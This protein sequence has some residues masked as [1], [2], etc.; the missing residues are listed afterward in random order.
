M[1]TSFQSFNRGGQFQAS[2]VDLGS[3]QQQQV[4][5]Q[6]VQDLE[7]NSEAQRQRDLQSARETEQA[8]QGLAQFSNS[9][10][11]IL[12]ERQKE[13]NEKQ[14]LEGMREYWFNGATEEEQA[15]FRADEQALGEARSAADKA[16]GDFEQGGGDVFVAERLRDL[17]GWKAYGFAKAMLNQAG[18]SYGTYYTQRSQELGLNET[19]DPRQ[20][21][22]IEQQIREDYMMQYAEMNPLLL[23]E[24][25]FPSMRKFEQAEQLAYANRQAKLFQKNRELTRKQDLLSTFASSDPTETAN[26]ILAWVDNH[27]GQFG[28]D[29]KVTFAAATDIIRTGLSDGSIDPSAFLNSLDA[30][31]T[32]RDGSVMT[33]GEFR[34]KDLALLEEAARSALT[35]K[36]NRD[37]EFNKNTD[38]KAYID[39]TNEWKNSDKSEEALARI[40]AKYR[41]NDP[42]YQALIGSWVTN[43]DYDDSLIVSDIE[44]RLNAG[45]PVPLDFVNRISD[46]ETREDMMEKVTTND[47]ISPPESVLEQ[48]TAQIEAAVKDETGIYEYDSLQNLYANQNA[49]AHYRMLY[50]KY[51]EE[52][53]KVN[54]AAEKAAAET[55]KM[56]PEQMKLKK[57]GFF[58][59][60]AVLF[61]TDNMKVFADIN[62]KADAGEIDFDSKI[63]G[64]DNQVRQLN[65]A[66]QSKSGI[67]DFWRTL[68][69]D[70]GV[71]VYKLIDTQLRA[72]GYE[73]FNAPKTYSDIEQ[74]PRNTRRLV[75]FHKTDSRELRAAATQENAR[76][77]LDSIASVESR[78]HGEYNAFNLGG[79]SGGHVAIGS[80]DSTTDLD[81]PITSMT[82]GEIK[83]RHAE[84]SLHAVGRY[85]FIAPT[86]LETA[87]L[88][89]LDDNQVFDEKTQD[90]F[91]LTRAAVRI[92]EMN[93]GSVAGLSAEWIGL[94]NLPAGQVQQMVAF[95]LNLPP[96]RQL[97][98][99]LPGVAKA[100]LKPN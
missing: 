62:A 37:I 40:T 82:I 86:F 64:V 84:G 77:F 63:E 48:H 29:T 100:T 3:Q 23:H 71:D 80:G 17:S 49:T 70:H 38:R 78:S 98:M 9:L 36:L 43:E 22:A 95:G 93:G 19:A 96:Y 7:R 44:Q 20:R 6:L 59:R 45:L 8:A 72:Y 35:T 14:M 79:A 26:N 15:Q 30:S 18:A 74:Y 46:V 75:Q 76:W 68:A 89:G 13:E 42:Q 50:Q 56:I 66:L 41:F 83:Q 10:S 85:Q 34:S 21:A 99:L 69:D 58:Q 67:P 81:K 97:H 16:A 60:P 33:L 32:R 88:I 55:I 4:N 1:T 28:G 52:G 61:Q 12:V 90:L 92:R 5:Q 65:D 91:A 57:G 54:I 31:V 25:L 94:N 73:G 11:S 24:H 51:R 39:A 53:D 27:K 2:Q 87:N 47:K